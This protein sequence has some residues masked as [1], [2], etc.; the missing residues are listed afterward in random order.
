M[1]PY[2]FEQ[3]KNL[4]VILMTLNTSRTKELFCWIW[5]I[6]KVSSHFTDFGQP[7]LLLGWL[8]LGWLLFRWLLT[9]SKWRNVEYFANFGQVK[10]GQGNSLRRNR[11][12]EHFWA[13]NLC[14]LHSTLTSQTC[15]G[16]HQLWAL[17]Q[18]KAVLFLFERLGIQF[19]I[20]HS[21]VT[22][23]RPCHAR[24]HSHSCLEKQGISLGVEIVLSI[25]LCSHT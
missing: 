10:K 7:K 1:V 19:F 20:L 18:H 13:T 24:C 21:H 4:V 8:L 23:G 9:L 12:P 6:Q 15:D 3:V 14:H 25:C 11:M 22:Y 2:S 5:T 16:L 17:P